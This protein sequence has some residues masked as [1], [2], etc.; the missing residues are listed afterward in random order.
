MTE[1]VS[2]EWSFLRMERGEEQAK[3][4]TQQSSL[5]VKRQFTQV[6]PPLWD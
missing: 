1:G 3:G 6:K 2:D 4:L 5:M